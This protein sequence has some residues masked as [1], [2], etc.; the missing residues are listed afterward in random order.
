[1]SYLAC[2]HYLLS[3][4][5]DILGE[6]EAAHTGSAHYA[7]V[8]RRGVRHLHCGKLEKAFTERHSAEQK[9]SVK[10]NIFVGNK[11][12]MVKY[13]QKCSIPPV[14][15]IARPILVLRT[16]VT[17][18]NAINILVALKR[19]IISAQVTQSISLPCSNVQQNK[20]R[21]RTFLLC[22]RVSHQ[23]LS[24]LSPEKRNI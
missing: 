8:T 2:V 21:L 3:S 20:Y 14:T 13:H 18:A 7:M 10:H 11:K 22:R 19:N 16:S 5:Y 23:N 1:M 9:L 24:G 12:E 4:V 17:T 15:S 6:G